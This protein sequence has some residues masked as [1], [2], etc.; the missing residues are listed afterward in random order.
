MWSSRGIRSIIR[1]ASFGLSRSCGI[2][3]EK[4][5]LVVGE[6]VIV[7]ICEKITKY[8]IPYVEDSLKCDWRFSTF[9]PEIRLHLSD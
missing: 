9:W 1:T 7:R 2:C 5:S 6:I 8:E 4:F 3:E